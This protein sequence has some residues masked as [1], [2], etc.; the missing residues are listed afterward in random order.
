[1]NYSKLVEVRDDVHDHICGHT[2]PKTG[3][4][5]P[6]VEDGVVCCRRCGAGYAVENGVFPHF[7]NG[8][9]WQCLEVE[10]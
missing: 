2:S 5:Y 3:N 1:M 7:E 8:T 10:K 4:Y 6:L 9:C